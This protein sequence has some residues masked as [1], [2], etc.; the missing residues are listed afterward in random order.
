MAGVNEKTC[1]NDETKEEI[2]SRLKR[3]EGQL[4]GIQRMIEEERSCQDLVMQLVAVKSA[5][6]QV[7]LTALSNQFIHC[8]SEAEVNGEPTAQITAKFIE[9]FKKLS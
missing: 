5:I 2:L 7:A 8:L 6:T 4:R 9:I 1:F 3:A